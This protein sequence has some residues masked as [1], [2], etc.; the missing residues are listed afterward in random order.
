MKCDYCGKET[1]KN[2]FTD[3][4]TILCKTC[5][6]G[7]FYG[8]ADAKKYIAAKSGKTCQNLKNGA[9]K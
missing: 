6:G 3:D 8:G 2:Y 9:K 7:P 5:A 1:P 4:F